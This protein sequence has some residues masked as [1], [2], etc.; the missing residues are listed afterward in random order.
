MG[1][2]VV[3]T[4]K[5]DAE[6]G[7]TEAVSRS[8]LSARRQGFKT[9]IRFDW[10]NGCAWWFDSV[11]NPGH[12]GAW[13]REGERFAACVGTMHWQGVTGKA[14]LSRLLGF[15]DDPAAMPWRDISGAFAVV[16]GRPGGVWLATDSVGLQKVFHNPDQAVLSTSFVVCLD[17]SP[18]KPATVNAV[19]AAEYVMFGA[20][21]GMATP[22][23]DV[24]LARP[25]H[26]HDL[27]TGRSVE[28][29]A[30]TSWLVACPYRAAAEA[31]EDISARI[32]N[33]FA[34]MCRAFGTRIGMA[35]SGGFDSR[36]ILAA[37]DR[38]GV[39]PELFVYGRAH[40]ADVTVATRVAGAMGLA[41]ECVDKS[42]VDRVLPALSAET[43]GLNVD[44]FDGMPNDGIFDRGSDR[45]TRLQQ[46]EGGKLNLNGG[47]G[48]I[49][50]N[51]FYLKNRPYSAAKL[52]VAFYT[53][54]VDLAVP[55]ARL[56]TELSEMLQDEVLCSLGRQAASRAARTARLP[57]AEIELVYSLLR[58]RGAQ[59]WR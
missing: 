35:L 9:P 32:E 41:I 30:P 38:S 19:R 23:D 27:M 34:S 56:R 28:I 11:P 21:H 14:L 43:L 57:R 7:E 36:L 20:N 39:Q 53:S 46:L 52:V 45:L 8:L 12:G 25:T 40:D 37:L 24:R 10:V 5:P 49:L 54:G 55:D 4:N 3:A 17:A 1:L 58:L 29:H 44:F 33:D 6:R 16:M 22:F 2:I 26:A 15:G 47:G 48:E 42:V 50:R 18:R 51:F 13:C 31:V 59:H